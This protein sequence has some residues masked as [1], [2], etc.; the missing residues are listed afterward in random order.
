M[1]RRALVFSILFH[2]V[3]ACVLLFGIDFDPEPTPIAVPASKIVQ[4][5]AVDQNAL[6]AEMKKLEARDAAKRKAEEDRRQEAERKAKEAE[7][8]RVA[9][10]KRVRELKAEQERLKKAE[11][12]ER[13]RVAEAKRKA[14]EAEHEAAE[15]KQRAE[16]ERIAAEQAQ[17][18]REQR[19][20]EQKKAAEQKRREQEMQEAIAA[21]EAAEAAAAQATADANELSKYQAAIYNRVRQSWTILPGMD[22]LTC[23]LR[24]VLIPGGEVA[25]VEIIQSSG[26]A[27]FDRQAENAVRKASPLPVPA[28]ARLFQ[29][30]RSITFVFDPQ[31]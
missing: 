19:E 13:K 5:K 23:T 31:S 25:G 9:E 17:A 3:L 6:A 20:A 22:G 12:V 30:M 16:Q 11:E 18:A 28:Q 4:A 29:K 14:E 24:I 27:T 15:R 1:S 8:K 10:E 21:E 26:N 7:R 2:V